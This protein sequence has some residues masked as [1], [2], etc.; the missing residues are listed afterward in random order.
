MGGMISGELAMLGVS[1][2]RSA[3]IE[4]DT[5]CTM[6]E[7]T[8]EKGMTI[9]REFQDAR[10]H[11]SDII[12]K[13]L[14]RTVPGRLLNHPLFKCFDRKLRTLLGLYC[15]RCVY[16]PG[17][18]IAKEGALG[19]ALFIVNQGMVILEKKGTTIKSYAAGAYFGTTVM[20]G[21]HKHYFITI[22]AL[23]T[24]HVLTITRTSYMHTLEKYPSQA[25][26]RQFC[27][28][29]TKAEDELRDMI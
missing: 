23:Q 16:Y 25:I 20:L 12:V 8:Q 4:A 22:R 7:V 15:E 14:E 6:W 10:K 17:C 9:L 11:F 21:L 1:N 26:S 13:H 19:D 24:C 2:I 27:K 18:V 28:K 5:I 3:T 29:E